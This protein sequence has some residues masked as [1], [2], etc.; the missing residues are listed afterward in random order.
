MKP[1]TLCMLIIFEYYLHLDP[2]GDIKIISVNVP[3]CDAAPCVLKKGTN[4]TV[5]VEFMPC[6]LQARLVIELGKGREYSQC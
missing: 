6:K 2:S 1:L 4:A 3:G 5:T